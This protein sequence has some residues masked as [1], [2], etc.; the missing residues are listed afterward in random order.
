MNKEP[1][2]LSRAKIFTENWFESDITAADRVHQSPARGERLM[3][4]VEVG[5]TVNFEFD[6][7]WQIGTVV[8]AIAGGNLDIKT[9][10]NRYSYVPASSVTK[11]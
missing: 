6:G 2:N 8:R 4:T 11:R 5:D 9:M 3:T 10:T 7:I 1:G